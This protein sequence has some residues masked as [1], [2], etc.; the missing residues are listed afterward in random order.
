MT[1]PVKDALAIVAFVATVAVFIGV[2]S[3][4]FTQ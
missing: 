2:H 4:M 3:W 1:K